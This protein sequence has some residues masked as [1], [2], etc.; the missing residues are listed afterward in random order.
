M[1]YSNIFDH[2]HSNIYQIIYV[3]QEIQIE[4]LLNN[5]N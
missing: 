3:L 5:K 1:I 2:S 4:N